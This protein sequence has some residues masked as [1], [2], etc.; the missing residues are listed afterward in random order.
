MAKK[1]D[2]VIKAFSEVWYMGL[3]RYDTVQVKSDFTE[4]L[5]LFGIK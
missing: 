3:V 2:P 5:N 1:A 4:V